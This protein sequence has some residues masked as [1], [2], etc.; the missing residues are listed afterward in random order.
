MSSVIV[1]GATPFGGMSNE[2][3]EKI[4]EVDE[5]IARLEAAVAVAASG[6]AGTPGTEYE[7][8]TNFGVVPS[9]V[10]GAK[11]LDYAFAINSLAGQWATFKTAAF[12]AI[13]QLDNG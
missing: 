7:T 8:G 6:F 4:W 11:G 9:A 10:P 3:V 1:N 5:S 2:M 13:K 12:A